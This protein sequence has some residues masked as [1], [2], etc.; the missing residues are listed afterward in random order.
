MKRQLIVFGEDWGGLPSSTQ[1]IIKQL[2]N[3]YSVTWINSLGLRSPKA[4]LHD[5][6]RIFAKAG[7]MIGQLFNGKKQGKEQSKNQAAGTTIDHQVG[8]ATGDDFTV[9]EP[10]YIPI[11]SSQ[12]VRK[13]NR[14]LLHG[15][16]KRCADSN[17]VE[18]AV[19]WI[20]LPNAV[21][22]LHYIE[23]TDL[24]D[25]VV[26]YYCCDDFAAL[27]GVDHDAVAV[28][29][30]ELANRA[31]FIVATSDELVEK[32]PEGK[33]HMIPH[34]VDT[35]LFNIPAPRA[36]D[37]PINKPVAGF[38]GSIA[39][40]IDVDLLAKV[41]AMMPD[42]HFV[43]IGAAKVDIS[44]LESLDNVIFLGPKPHSHLPRYSQHWDVSLLP[45]ILNEQIIA[46]NPL[47]LREYM[48]AGRPI[49]SIDFP[50]VHQYGEFIELADGP[51]QFAAAIKR[52]HAQPIEVR[53]QR[54]KCVAAESWHAVAGRINALIQ[55]V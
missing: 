8:L 25:P 44:A 14:I 9:V 17:A 12:L 32:F 24:I 48:A 33:T 23:Q 50:Q 51:Q 53:E 38:Y 34:G 21:D 55:E 7:R 46:S 35:A 43:L 40:W 18:R 19:V 31:D 49:V 30:R 16:M 45:F 4:N 39:Q 22:A 28:F 3:D 52:A 20:S 15:L 29:E 1:H 36:V 26:V 6:K 2:S 5:L 47:K 13:L 37:L 11:L 27:D 41:A 42:W 10:R 54:Q